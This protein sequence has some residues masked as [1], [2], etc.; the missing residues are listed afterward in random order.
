MANP[1]EN[2]QI[3]E[4]LA[5]INKLG[6]SIEQTFKGISEQAKKVGA[7]SE[8]LAKNLDFSKSKDIETL[9]AL[10]NDLTKRVDD[11]T[12][13]NKKR[14]KTNDQLTKQEK[15]LLKL[16]KD[17]S[18]TTKEL[19]VE[20]EELKLERQASTK[21]AREQA[22][23]NKGLT[24]T[25]DKQRKRLN[26]L[27][28]EL[29]NAAVEGRLNEESVRAQRE[30]FEQLFT[31]ITEAE[32]QFGNFRRQV[33]NYEKAAED[34]S[35]TT[36]EL[37]KQLQRLQR[38]GLAVGAV[39]AGGGVINRGIKSNEE[40]FDD[41][42]AASSALEK[43]LTGVAS[44]LIGPVL[45]L[46][47]A[48]GFLA[49]A[50]AVDKLGD[51]LKNAVPNF[52]E[53]FQIQL[54]IVKASQDF[55]K[56]LNDNIDATGK[57]V[58]GLNNQLLEQQILFERNLAISDLNTKNLVE[59]TKSLDEAANASQAAFEIE[60]QIVNK[61]LDLA[62]REFKLAQGNDALRLEARQKLTEAE[63]AAL[64][65]QARRDQARIELGERR[66]QLLQD[67]FELD[68][69][70]LIDYSD[71]IK[72]INERIISDQRNALEVRKQILTET[73]KEI[74]G[75]FIEQIRLF[76][77]LENEQRRIQKSI[78]E[79]TDL[80]NTIL[81]DAEKLNVLT[82]DYGQ[83]TRQINGFLALNSEQLKDQLRL[84]G[85]SEQAQTRFLKT[86]TEIRTQRA[87][88]NELSDSLDSAD[89]IFGNV[90]LE[91][92]R[93]K[94]I[95]ELRKQFSDGQLK[96]L[97]EFKQKE[98]EINKKFDAL[99][100][101]EFEKR[102]FTFEEELKIFNKITDE[103]STRRK[104]VSNLQSQLL[105]EENEKKKVELEKSLKE[106]I[107]LLRLEEKARERSIERI[108]KQQEQQ[109]Q[110]E[111]RQFENRKKQLEEEAELREELIDQFVG[112]VNVVN[113]LLNDLS[114]KRIEQIDNEIAAL[115]RRE[116]QV[117]QSYD[118]GSK[119]AKKSITEIDEER[120]RLEEEREK[121]FR[122]EAARELFVAG[123]NVL[124]ETG[125]I[126]EA[127]RQLAILS[128][129]IPAFVGGFHDGGYTG[130]GNEYA[131]AGIVHKGEHV[132][133]KEQTGKYGL[134]HLSADD[135]DRAVET[136]YFTQFA[137]PEYLQYDQLRPTVS[138]TLDQS[139]V[140][141]RLERV[142]D[143]I[144]LTIDKKPQHN[145]AW[146]EMRKEMVYEISTRTKVE[147]KRRKG[148]RY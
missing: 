48:E 105:N 87:E 67:Q 114:Q 132:I 80:G 20:I 77:E 64:D 102:N 116:D 17:Q 3:A 97:E 2:K 103:I 104:N 68:L 117:R 84:L 30:E 49:S 138:T 144:L 62:R 121:Q 63:A 28:K 47:E 100:D 70:I 86:L 108:R 25:L 13:A 112:G 66:S 75:S 90:K 73:D 29:T 96:S 128:A 92:D 79:G 45:D 24:T 7:N 65:L 53:I 107:D 115:H 131:A 140:I 101:E 18:E 129:A 39:V 91:Q 69:D 5:E 143:A 1:I 123:A 9:N 41:L 127:L 50:A 126:N 33:G 8:E 37:A 82:D 137:N 4:A 27:Q 10:L 118:Q 98:A 94:E 119:F 139:Q 120:R 52:S 136:G 55:Q 74:R 78:D 38:I 148:F 16:Q 72:S 111:D 133:T 43:S 89:P 56:A 109:G 95:Q 6:K 110:F 36:Q 60:E 71:N 122:Q 134:R 44:S 81:T 51:A 76:E 54:S 22:K 125:D 146:D 40:A 21:A 93:Q 34:A 147:R 124:A 15:T 135:F 113:D 26:E 99:A 46:F 88:L 42:S 59:R 19:S 11:L 141:N 14:K 31:T 145:Q 32:Q 58:L 106:E 142:E 61:R 85:L 83:S 23:E 12:D 35:K 130:D 57:T